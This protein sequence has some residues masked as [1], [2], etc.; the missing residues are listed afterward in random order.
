MISIRKLRSLAETTRDRKVARLVEVWIREGDLGSRA[1]ER[2]LL[3]LISADTRYPE[4]IR[5]AAARVDLSSTEASDVRTIR[6]LD[7]LRG[8]LS[9]FLR[10]EPAEWDL[11]APHPGDARDPVD[12]RTSSAGGDAIALYLESLRSPFNVGSIVRTAAAFG[13]RCVGSS[14]DTPPFSHPRA[15]RS[16]MGAGHRL[17]LWQGGFA[18]FEERLVDRSVVALETGG[19]D[20]YRATLPRHAILVVG[21]EELGVSP[22]LLERA[23]LRVSVPLRGSKASLNVGVALG[24]A[25]SV[26]D[27]QAT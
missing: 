19:V 3:S 8:H 14:P 23:D 24:I 2:E 5:S 6:A 20:I 10:L 26:W 11:V 4:E 1:F 12:V 22:D 13:V 17:D 25:L 7:Q 27:S 21:S 15:V 16:A 18:E 9:A